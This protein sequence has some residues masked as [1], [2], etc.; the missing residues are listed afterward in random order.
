LF[1]K[2][3]VIKDITANFE[4]V[5]A[6]ITRMEL[7][8]LSTLLKRRSQ[9][10]AQLVEGV[11]ANDAGDGDEGAKTA[12]REVGRQNAM[13]RARVETKSGQNKEKLVQLY[14]RARLEKAY[15]K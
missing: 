10:L 4:V 8:L 15:Q 2:R 7:D 13:I 3:D 1:D 5:Q 12:L 14:Q 11:Q 9:L 6:A